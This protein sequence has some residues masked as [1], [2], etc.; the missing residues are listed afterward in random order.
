V[1][2]SS[3]T[4]SVSI[5][6]E[7]EQAAAPE[8]SYSAVNLSSATGIPLTAAAPF[9]EGE[10]GPSGRFAETAPSAVSQSNPSRLREERQDDVPV[11]TA[12][13]YFCGDTSFFSL[14]RALQTIASQKL[15]GT[16]RLFWKSEP[17]ELLAHDGQIVLVTTRDP[18]LY[19]PD[20]PFSLVNIGLEDLERARRQQ[21][22]TGRPLFITLSEE[23]LIIKEPAM[24]LVQHYGQKL[25]AQLWSASRLRFMFEQTVALPDYV[26]G[27]PAEDDVDY[28]LLCALRFVQHDELE[29]AADYDPASVPAYTRDGFDRVQRLHL[30]VAEAQFASQFNGARSIAQIA[31]NL[32]FDLKLARLTL[33]RFLALEIV[34]CWPPAALGAQPEKRGLFRRIFGA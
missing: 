22:E 23:D 17:V 33:F 31:K 15:T 30:T 18:H 13:A 5:L 4:H 6:A 2:Q 9:R 26:N 10:T 24:Q 32:R 12:D 27:I 20:S 16:L 19:C 28:W 34:E 21:H 11:V 29:S 7:S 25:F 14:T 1:K 8:T 3:S